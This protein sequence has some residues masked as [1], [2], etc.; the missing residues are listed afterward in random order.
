MEVKLVVAEVKRLEVK[1]AG[2]RINM[3]PVRVLI[4]KHLAATK[5][6]LL[7][8]ELE[9]AELRIQGR[10]YT[11]REVITVEPPEVKTDL[12]WDWGKV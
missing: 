4:P 7:L 11:I 9:R 1:Q 12:E 6:V 10:E 5:A 3:A 2:V 8:P